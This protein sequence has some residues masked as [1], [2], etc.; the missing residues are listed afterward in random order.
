MYFVFVK[1]IYL[2]DKNVIF[3]LIIQAGLYYLFIYF[4]A[5]GGGGG[6]SCY[7]SV[8]AFIY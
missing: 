5:G 3:I 1:V 2:S 7:Q 6:G 8:G 4:L